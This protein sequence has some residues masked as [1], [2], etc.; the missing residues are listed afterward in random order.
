MSSFLNQAR[1][2]SLRPIA[3]LPRPRLTIVP[4]AAARAPRIPFVLL[5]VGILAAGLVGLLLVNIALQRGA[6]T[7]TDLRS[8]SASLAITQQNLELEVAALREPQRV[9]HRAV[10]LGM[11]RNDSPA[12]L[13]LSTGKVIGTAVPALAAN[14]VDVGRQVS[15]PA[16]GRTKATAV[17]AGEANTLSAGVQHVAGH[18]ATPTDRT[19][20]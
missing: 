1:V 13:E 18:R 14:R 16:A 5:V 2:R 7:V 3:M 6:Y 15:S 19:R 10:Q 20:Q 17:R 8:R 12:F 11:V 9:A 4:A